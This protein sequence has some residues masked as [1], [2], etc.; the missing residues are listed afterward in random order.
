MGGSSAGIA[1]GPFGPTVYSVARTVRVPSG[2]VVPSG[3]TIAA[4][5]PAGTST[6][7]RRVPSA[8]LTGA[9]RCTCITGAPAVIT[10]VTGSS[11]TRRT[12]S[13]TT[14]SCQGTVTVR[15]AGR[16]FGCW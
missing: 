14:K 5:V 15:C 12:S 16:V 3:S 1:S 8:S 10:V 6:V 2:W 7:A 11:G 13:T 4:V 9:A